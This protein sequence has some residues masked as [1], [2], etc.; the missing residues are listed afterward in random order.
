M[1][2]IGWTRLLAA[3]LCLAALT[4]GALADSA[5]YSGYYYDSWGELTE[6]PNIYLPGKEYSALDMALGSALNNPSDMTIDAE[7]GAFFIADTGNNRIVTLDANLRYQGEIEGYETENGYVY[8]N[9]PQ[10]V[11]L[12]RQGNLLI[13]DTGNGCVVRLTRSGEL[14]GRYA[15]P[16]SPLY[17]SDISFL[18]TKV[19]SDLE[20]NVYALVPAIYQGIVLFSEAGEFLN[21]FG[22]NTVNVTPALLLDYYWKKL[23]SQEQAEKMAR[24]VPINYLSMAMARDGYLYVTLYSSATKQHIRKLNALGKNILRVETESKAAYGDLDILYLNGLRTDTQ[25]ADIAVSADGF[26]YALDSK[27]GRVFLYSQ[28]SDSLG[29]FGGSGKQTGMFS[30]ATAIECV[31]DTVYVLDR[32]KGSVTAFDPTAFGETCMRAVRLYDQGMYADSEMLWR[33]ILTRN[34]QFEL[35]YDGIGK[36][37]LARGEYQAAL[38]YFEQAN[39]TYWYSKAFGEYRVE[40]ARMLLPWLMLA[41]LVLIVLL[42]ALRRARARRAKAQKAPTAL[43]LALRTALHPISAYAEIREHGLYSPVWGAV[44]LVG[45]FF[46]TV[47]QYQYTGFLFNGH[48]SD[49]INILVILA[50]TVGLFCLLMA[51]NNALSTFMDGESTFKA[52]W[53]CCAYALLPFLALELAAFGLSFLLTLEES[54]FLTWLHMLGYGW[55]LWQVICA[56]QTMQQYTF[57]KT[58]CSLILTAVGLV[59]FL[60]IAFLFFSLLQ[61]VASFVRTVFDEI[62]LWQ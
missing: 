50:Q 58:V 62:L 27:R 17:P 18:P 49:S 24:Y 61:Q 45:W 9:A 55:L 21:F 28:G 43:R 54:V 34:G 53:I 6:S 8:L 41:G 57:G 4:S 39:D 22:G 36:A 5:A 20:N 7:S 37:M 44:M 23:L 31:G 51:V 35:A 38:P 25:L 59:I 16:V 33:E 14:L 60:F 48:Q 29:V 52:L 30:A 11:S 26:I 40:K 13:A 1:K 42:L 10:G 46:V 47:I 19:A 12:D 56:V 32:L 3:L 15:Q 2:R